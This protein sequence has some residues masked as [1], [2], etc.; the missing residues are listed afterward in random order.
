MMANLNIATL[1]I[2]GMNEKKKQQLLLDYL[3]SEKITCCLI[4]EHN[5]KCQSAI[6]DIISD[7]YDIFF[8]ASIK[9]KGGTMIL[10]D[11]SI[12]YSVIGLEM[13]HDSRIIS[14]KINIESQYLHILNVYAPSGTQYQNERED[15]FRNEILYYL[16]NNLS[17]T[18]WGGD[19][20]CII[21][22]T[23][24]SNKNSTLKSIALE[25][26]I[27]HLKLTDAWFVKHDKPIYTY[28]REN[29]GSRLDRFYV[30]DLRESIFNISVKNVCFS[31]HA[32]V[33]LSLSLNKLGLRGRYYWKLN[34]SLL[35]ID[36]VHEN[37]YQFWLRIKRMINSYQNICD[38]WEHCAKP[39]IKA[40]FIKQGKIINEFKLGKIKYF[41]IK[42][43][44][45]C[46][47]IHTGENINISEIKRLKQKIH[48]LKCEVLEGAKIRSR[49]LDYTHG[50]K[51]SAFLIGKQS[52][53]KKYSLITKLISE[54]NTSDYIEGCEITEQEDLEKY[55][56]SSYKNIYMKSNTSEEDKSRFLSLINC[57]I[58]EEDNSI[59]NQTITLEEIYDI[60]KSM[61][62]NKSPGIDG[63]P[64]EFYQ[65]YWDIIKQ[66]IY[67]V[68]TQSLT[69]STLSESQRKAIIVLIEKGDDPNYL[70][71]WRP[72]S[73][74]CV[75]TK[76][77]AKIIAFRLKTVI[78]KCISKNQFCSPVRNIIECNN[79]M[80]DTIYYA[81]DN[82]IQ[83][84]IINIDWCKAFDSVD[85]DLL[86]RILLKMGFCDGFIKWIK[87]LYTEAVSS[88]IV[89][90][91]ITNIFNIERGV[92]QGC[93]LSMLLFV[94]F[95]EPLYRAIELSKNIKPIKLPCTYRKLLGFADDTSFIVAD[96]LSIIECFQILKKFELASSIK[97]N[98]KKTKLFG[99]GSW[100]NRQFW[101]I[102]G[103]RVESESMCILGI[104]YSND[105]D[106]ALSISWSKIIDAVRLKVNMLTSRTLNIYQKAII[107]NCI[108][109][110]KVWYTCHTY[111]LPYD[112]A[113]K[114]DQI[115]F[116]FI[117]NSKA[118]HLKRDVLY[119]KKDEGGI[120]LL[121]V[122]I[123]ASS[124]HAKSFLRLF[125]LNGENDSLI[126]YYCAVRLN[127][128]F[129][130]RELPH[131][132]NFSSVPF[133]DSDINVIRKCSKL[134]DFPNITS[135]N[136]YEST[137][138]KQKPIVEERYPLFI[139]ENIWANVASSVIN[140]D[141][142]SILFKYLHEILPN[143]LRLYNI[144][145]KVSPNCDTC[146][147][148]DNNLHMFYFCNKIKVVIK[149]LRVL[150]QRIL[151]IDN[152]NLIKLLFLDTTD[153]TNKD[154]N[155]VLA[156]ISSFICTI[157]YNRGHTG[158]KLII[159]KKNI[160]TNI[161]NHKTIFKNKMPK[162][163]NSQY[164][165]ID[166][167]FLD[168]IL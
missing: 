64:V 57:I 139:W 110:S 95:Q 91:F 58:N 115:I 122:H 75:D 12:K 126:K 38:W 113:K 20:N 52:K 93:P 145:R 133:Y 11:K 30:G 121:N 157:W 166:M 102:Q 24:V 70:S 168:N 105:Y 36:E 129:N 43:K 141:N 127:P 101:P 16:R 15:L 72:I 155:S 27:K 108:V 4:Q 135:Q 143:N 128:L 67:E 42:L 61:E 73:L 13:S 136:I 80:R 55:V 1:N 154:S 51:P 17:N 90:G 114:I 150:L 31:D 159:F 26:T 18:V 79:I 62:V 78:D 125:L 130:I 81:N 165:R 116:P 112:Y 83:G 8:N 134:K 118:N 131:N 151:N 37:F 132:I 45:I 85:H 160:M 138:Q 109:L 7:N 21:R 48:E 50:E 10:L 39:N 161:V 69:L 77:I 142:R 9:L 124:I 40:F 94:L 71:S 87:V 100:K 76:I 59:L 32:S 28:F 103:M 158:D 137:I 96:D 19:F 3:R 117:W 22:K 46:N 148:E 82:N 60:I 164:C 106:Q 5:L 2:N 119:N 163:F 86:F 35:N 156:I 33:I 41:E 56:S 107:I 104:H 6:Y 162:I 47:A 140:S 98:K 144:R 111:P 123:K 147:M 84:A 49:L 44:A 167:H 146:N 29:Y 66:E 53:K 65:T 25:N 97:L 152:V 14:L 63:I 89:N 120:N 149:Y 88:C 54:S 34:T 92:R 74:L 99:I 23:D 68:I 153:L